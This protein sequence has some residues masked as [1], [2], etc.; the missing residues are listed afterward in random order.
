LKPVGFA[1]L[2]LIVLLVGCAQSEKKDET[3][4]EVGEMG[5]QQTGQQQ[6]A[7]LKITSPAFA[8][9]DKIPAAYTC[10]GKDVSPQLDISGIPDGTKSLAL[11]VDDPD[12]PSG[13]W[14]H[15]VIWNISP[16]QKIEEQKIPAGASQGLNDFNEQG[17][18]GPC[19]PSGAHRYFFKL[20]ALDTTLKLPSD[21]RKQDLEESMH[22]H[23]LAQAQLIGVYSKK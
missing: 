13:T 5:M 23:I 20:Y 1:I 3:G 9:F 18:R 19:P 15:W 12:A 2:F 22:G 16:S 21:A 17:Y 10:Q 7:A 4:T 14:V 11:I 8:N 6:A